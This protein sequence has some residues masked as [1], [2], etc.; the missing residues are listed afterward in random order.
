MS[1]SLAAMSDSPAGTTLGAAS[2]A[3][4]STGSGAAAD[5]AVLKKRPREDGAI[6]ILPGGET[7]HLS[8]AYSPCFKEGLLHKLIHS[9]L[10]VKDEHGRIP[11]TFPCDSNA[12]ARAISE[13]E[14]VHVHASRGP[15]FHASR[16]P[17]FVAAINPQALA[18]LWDYLGLDFQLI[19]PDRPRPR[20]ALPVLA[21]Q[22]LLHRSLTLA[23]ELMLFLKAVRTCAARA[24]RC[25]NV[26]LTS[27]AGDDLCTSGTCRIALWLGDCP[28]L[29][30]KME[31]TESAKK[32]DGNVPLRLRCFSRELFETLAVPEQ[33]AALARQFLPE[34]VEEELK[35]ISLYYCTEADAARLVQLRRQT[36]II[37]PA[38]SLESTGCCETDQ[39]LGGFAVAVRLLQITASIRDKC[40]RKTF[41]VG[42]W[43]I[44]LKF[45]FF[46]E[47]DATMVEVSNT[48]TDSEG[49][50]WKGNFA[51]DR[52]MIVTASATL[53]GNAA[54]QSELPLLGIYTGTRNAH[55]E[56]EEKKAASLAVRNAYF[57]RKPARPGPSSV[58]R[59]E[60]PNGFVSKTL[61]GPQCQDIQC[62]NWDPVDGPFYLRSGGE[63][64]TLLE[65]DLY[66]MMMHPENNDKET[67]QAAVHADDKSDLLG[68]DNC[69]AY[70]LCQF[71][72]HSL[73]ADS[74]PALEAYRGDVSSP[75][76]ATN[77]A[78]LKI[79]GGR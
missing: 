18:A 13:H 29:G 7:F 6:F 56:D 5:T 76:T 61:A 53:T 75:E 8:A 31:W 11:F 62:K 3:T 33:T 32:E 51:S 19:D 70:M 14:N 74:S 47:S 27:M 35:L 48:F 58:F 17:P 37:A 30:S 10:T 36:L 64:V 22:M 59:A 52:R 26:T 54:Y 50:P 49:K 34:E 16:G 46:S 73:E 23:Q 1:D 21:S 63:P 68:A 28:Q 38:Y 57:D 42:D 41:K 9:E 67:F 78:W 15:P 40:D 66:E 71:E 2:G 65:R 12:F 39:L 77:C 43:A 44:E 55:D 4:G 25:S 72:A 60:A 24:L 20:T 79:D 45:S 69:L